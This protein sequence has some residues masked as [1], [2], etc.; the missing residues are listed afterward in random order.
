MAYLCSR[1]QDTGV[2]EENGSFITCTFCV[3]RQRFMSSL[4]NAIKQAKRGKRQQLEEDLIAVKSLLPEYPVM[5]ML[6]A[7]AR[8]L[9]RDFM[10]FIMDTFDIRP[11]HE[12]VD[13]FA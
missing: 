1:C 4:T 10:T 2:Y 12:P 11:L 13:R 3:G 9:R 7:E 5:A 8:G 6:E